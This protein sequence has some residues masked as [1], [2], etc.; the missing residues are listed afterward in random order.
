MFLSYTHLRNSGTQMPTYSEN[1]THI[2]TEEYTC[3]DAVCQPMSKCPHL[4]VAMGLCPGG[5]H[6]NPPQLSR[7][8]N[9]MHRGA[10][11]TTVCRAVK[12]WT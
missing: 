10:W 12:S 2:H 8:E 1:Y 5:G 11:V 9:P 6:G 3:K 7:L 4:C